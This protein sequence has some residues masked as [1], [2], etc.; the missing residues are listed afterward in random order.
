MKDNINETGP[1]D[2]GITKPGAD[3]PSEAEVGRTEVNPK[4]AKEA[5]I[6]VTRTKKKLK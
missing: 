1:K 3:D 4:V 6:D 2:L 5:L